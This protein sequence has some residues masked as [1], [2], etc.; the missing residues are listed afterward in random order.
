MWK[1]DNNS[2]L[3]KLF[4]DIKVNKYISESSDDETDNTIIN[5]LKNFIYE[6]ILTYFE[7]NDSIEA[8]YYFN[9]GDG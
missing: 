9:S 4:K 7:K 5:N 3:N 1:T 2:E 6:V 8:L